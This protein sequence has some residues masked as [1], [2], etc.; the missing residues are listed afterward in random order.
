MNRKTS[1]LVSIIII[2]F[3]GENNLLR[4]L[5]SV[6]NLS[7]LPFEV[8]VVDNA[9]ADSSVVSAKKFFGSHKEIPFMLVCNR[10]NEGFARANNIGFEKAKGNYILL[11][12][13]DTIVD[14]QFLRRLLSTLLESDK[15]G[16]VQPKI[17]F[18]K[19]KKLQSGLTFLTNTGVIRYVG[20][21]ADP[22]KKSFNNKSYIFSA[23][24]ACLL[25]RREVIEKAG[26]FDD[27]FF[28]YYEESDFCHRA[29]LAGFK[30][31][32]EPSA[33]VFHEGG[34]TSNKLGKS[35]IF[36]HSFKNRLTSI[37]KNFELVNIGYMLP[38]TLTGYFFLVFYYLLT[39][40]FFLSSSLVKAMTWNLINISATMRKRKFIQNKVRKVRDGDY[41]PLITYKTGFLYYYRLLSHKEKEK[42]E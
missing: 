15:N 42:F 3:N 10:K 41:I 5:R 35:F 21:G 26:L 14:S 16:V 22:N 32:Y 11:L 7:Y 27:D 34:Q 12:N 31:L 29:W 28:A 18:L 37:I 2:N 17:V 25:T 39:G 40:K 38:F 9:S 30:V 13:N 20:Y 24:G 36:F 33:L 8:I 19:S 23:N 6:V 1:E 4:C